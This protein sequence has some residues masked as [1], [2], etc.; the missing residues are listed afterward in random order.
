[1]NK[2]TIMNADRFVYSPFESEQI[3]QLF[4]GESHPRRVPKSFLQKMRVGEVDLQKLV[5]NSSPK[6]GC[7]RG[8]LRYMVCGKARQ[9]KGFRSLTSKLTR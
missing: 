5:T 4:K 9:A 3:P 7:F 8:V 1:V 6:I 2:Q